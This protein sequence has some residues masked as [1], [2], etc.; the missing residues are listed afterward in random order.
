MYYILIWAISDIHE[1]KNEP[2]ACSRI[3]VL[4]VK[5]FSGLVTYKGSR[6]HAINYHPP[7]SSVI[8]KH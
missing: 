2:Q 8:V 6:R 3:Y 4:T 1:Q 5:A 7:C